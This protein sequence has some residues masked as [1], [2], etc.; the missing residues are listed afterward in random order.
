MNSQGYNDSGIN[1]SEELKS[2]SIWKSM[3]VNR[4]NAS[5]LDG[6]RVRKPRKHKHKYRRHRHN[7]DLDDET[8]ERKLSVVPDAPDLEKI[9]N[10]DDAES[11][12]L[13]LVT[14]DSADERTTPV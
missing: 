11:A 13:P 2:T 12:A 3:V 4:G 10:D 1:I 14:V 8:L 9:A 6:L 5:N 7:K